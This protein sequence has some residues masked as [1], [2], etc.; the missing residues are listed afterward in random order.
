MLWFK[1]HIIYQG[2]RGIESKVILTTAYG[3]IKDAV[4][5]IKAGAYNFVEKNQDEEL[6]LTIRPAVEQVELLRESKTIKTP[7]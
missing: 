7:K 4:D 6:K 3:K 1:A 5:A 2:I